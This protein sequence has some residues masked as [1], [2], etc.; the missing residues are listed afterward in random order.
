MDE[1]YNRIV[2]IG[3]GFDKALGLKTSYHDF[4]LSLIKT[5][6]LDTINSKN[7]LN[8]LFKV[9][10]ISNAFVNMYDVITRA[11]EIKELLKLSGILKINYNYTFL[12]EIVTSYS[13]AKW[14]DIEQYYYKQLCSFYDR[15]KNTINV[16]NIPKYVTDL[17]I[18][19][20]EITLELNKYISK[21]RNNSLVNY[22]HNHL[23]KLFDDFQYP[24]HK[25]ISSLVKNHN[26]K[27]S[28]SNVLF[29]NFNYTD[30]V[31]KMLGYE[32]WTENKSHHISIHGK[33]SSTS[34][35][36]I[37]GYGDDTGDIYK[38][39]ELED[40]EWLRMIKS[41][42]YPR[43]NNYHKLLNFLSNI[44]FDVFIVG[45][46]CGMSDKTLL[47][48]IFEHKNC[49]AIQNYHYKGE[50]EDFNKRMQISRHFSDKALMRERVL[51]F[52][53]H[54]TIPQTP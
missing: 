53:K 12:K 2:L 23:S 24:L 16:K 28:P 29:L 19:M 52:D 30:S 13:N 32:N 34:N 25:D 47:K 37:F 17:N 7:N 26:R 1:A 9:K 8:K 42:Q 10:Q 6:M 49:L 15:Y 22:S 36:I 35:P 5:S 51:P 33:V 11:T 46:S 43:T 50:E 48:T 31:E 41:F 27:N 20:D 40:D 54:A 38:E 3:N 14:V 45:H 18:C 21:L 44:A 39:L 4:I